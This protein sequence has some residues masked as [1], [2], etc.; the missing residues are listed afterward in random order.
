MITQQPRVNT[1]RLNNNK[2]IKMD[3]TSKNNIGVP[4]NGNDQSGVAE[5]HRDI[6]IDGKLLGSHDRIFDLV[7]IVEDSRAFGQR[8]EQEVI[9]IDGRAYER[10]MKPGEVIF[11]LNDITQ[12]ECHD[13]IIRKI[14]EIAERVAKEI[15]PGIAEKVIREEIEKLKG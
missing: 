12:G 10:I 3:E 15:I 2:D 4:L 1:H 13:D 5:D 11:D 8:E 9:V 7:D 6:L 14:S